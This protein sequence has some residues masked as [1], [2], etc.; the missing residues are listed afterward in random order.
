M[1][2]VESWDGFQQQKG[3]KKMQDKPVDPK[4]LIKLGT[5]IRKPFIN[6]YCKQ[7][8]KSCNNDYCANLDN[9]CDKILYCMGFFY[10]RK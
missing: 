10:K 5:P 2:S 4:Y 8:T 1:K 6:G 3:G 7:C 9:A